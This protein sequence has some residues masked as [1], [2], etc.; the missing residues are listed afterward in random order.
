MCMRYLREIFLVTKHEY[1]INNAIF[2]SRL[3]N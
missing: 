1:K 2:Q 3:A